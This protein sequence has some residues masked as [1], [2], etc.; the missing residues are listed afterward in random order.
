MGQQQYRD[1]LRVK[2]CANTDS[3]LIALLRL[4][5][6]IVI[7]PCGLRF[8]NPQTLCLP[9]T[10][11]NHNFQCRNRAHWYDSLKQAKVTCFFKRL[12]RGCWR[13]DAAAVSCR[14][15]SEK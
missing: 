8:Y 1:V 12:S 7:L 3:S 6:R 15:W 13:C 2:E 4:C 14:V 11:M 5:V 10:Q 9:S